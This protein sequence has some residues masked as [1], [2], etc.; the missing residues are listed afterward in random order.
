MSKQPICDFCDCA[1]PICADDLGLTPPTLRFC[2]EHHDELG[3]YIKAENVKAILRFWVQSHG[4]A[5]RMAD[6][7]AQDMANTAARLM[8]VLGPE[9]QAR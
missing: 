3:G 6:E 1:K 8:D 4:G 7:M 5:K 2:Q 9:G